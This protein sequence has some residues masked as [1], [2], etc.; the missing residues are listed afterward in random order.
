MH[1]SDLLCGVH[2][3]RVIKACW[4][5]GGCGREVARDWGQ[6]QV[7]RSGGRRRGSVRLGTAG[8]DAIG[9]RLGGR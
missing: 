8:L 3:E 9:N 7:C 2:E 6:E 1:V 4:A 5:G